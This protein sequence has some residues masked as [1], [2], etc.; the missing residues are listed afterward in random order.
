MAFNPYDHV[1]SMISL[2]EERST[3]LFGEVRSSFVL[4]YLSSQI[5]AD[6]DDIG[7]TKEQ[8]SKLEYSLLRMKRFVENS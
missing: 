2:I 6:L 5:Q 7:L 3:N 8:I 4:G 1:D